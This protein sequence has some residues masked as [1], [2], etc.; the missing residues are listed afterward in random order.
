VQWRELDAVSSN[1]YIL[2]SVHTGDDL[3]V[4]G[5]FAWQIAS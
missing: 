4:G 2:I 1:E 5:N 3:D